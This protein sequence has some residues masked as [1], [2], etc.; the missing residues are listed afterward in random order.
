MEGLNI[1]IL[2]GCDRTIEE[3]KEK[4]IDIFGENLNF[5]YIN[6]LSTELKYN[7]EINRCIKDIR[8]LDE[9]EFP[10]MDIV[11]DEHVP[12]YVFDNKVW[13]HIYS[14]L[15]S[16]GLFYKQYSKYPDKFLE[17]EMEYISSIVVTDYEEDKLKEA[18]YILFK[19]SEETIE[20]YRDKPVTELI[21]DYV[22]NYYTGFEMFEKYNKEI[23]LNQAEKNNF[24]YFGDDYFDDN[25]IIFIKS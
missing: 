2:G 14:R 20:F 25:F 24:K 9:C 8:N 3:Y 4:Y 1:L 11:I 21:D 16:G 12:L 5:Y 7:G 13:D 15:K 19:Y 10:L 23:I 6:Y 22:D 17:L 18:L